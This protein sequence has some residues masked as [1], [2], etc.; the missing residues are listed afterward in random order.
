MKDIR[1]TATYV[2]NLLKASNVDKYDFSLSE[3]ETREFNADLGV[4]SLYRTV[5]GNSLVVDVYKDNKKGTKA[6]N[7]FSDEALKATVNDA[8]LSAQS[9][10]ADPAYDIAP[11]QNKEVFKNGCYEPDIEKFFS[12]VKELLADVKVQYPKVRILNVYA[13]HTKKHD[14]YFNSNGTDFE[15]YDGYYSI[16]LE[17]SGNDGQ[18]STSL[19]AVQVSIYDLDKPFIELAGFKEHLENATNQLNQI[20]FSGKFEGTVLFTP[21]CFAQF[22]MYTLGNYVAGPVILDGTSL[23]LDKL[24]QQV[25]DKSLTLS[26]KSSDKR[27]VAGEKFTSDGFKT[28]DVDI[29]K[30]GVLKNFMLNLYIANKTGRQVLKNTSSDFV[31]ANGTTSYTDILKSIDHGLLVGGFSGG[32]PGTNGEFSGVAKNSYLIENGEIKGAV[33]ETMING[34]LGEMLKH[35]KAIS[36]ETIADGSMVLPYVA[37]NGIVISGK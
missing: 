27:I 20:P 7:D 3:K 2:E 4:F 35:I 10:V 30:D 14:F 32:Q 1:K 23:W 22:L 8:V 28:E 19:D 37:V 9:A 15:D 5:F 17:F 26:L 18:K 31:M 29:I 36:K 6:G 12:R 11:K 21:D 25:A 16:T 24:G 34:N 13:S 33:S